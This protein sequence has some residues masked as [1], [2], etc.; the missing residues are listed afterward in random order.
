MIPEAELVKFIIQTVAD[1]EKNKP[2]PVSLE[3]IDWKKFKDFISYHELVS[4]AYIA[5]KDHIS[6]LPVDLAQTLKA[7]YYYT[8]TQTQKFWRRFLDIVAAAK[9]AG[10]VILPIKGTALLN[11]L[12]LDIPVR[13][14]VDVDLLVKEEDFKKA[15]DLLYKLGYQKE[16][17]GLTE[18]YWKLDQCHITYQGRGNGLPIAELHWG[19]DFKRNGR[20]I[21]PEIWQ[22]LREVDVDGQKIKLLS[23]E[24]TLFSLGLH[25]RRFGKTLCLKYACDV[26]L[27]LSK[28]KDSFDWRYILSKAKEYRL[29][30]VIYFILYN[31]KALSEINVPEYVWRDLGLPFWKRK[32]IHRFIEKNL[33]LSDADQKGKSLYLKSHFLLYD[34]L[35]EPAQYILNIP[36]EQFAKYYGLETY[37]KKTGFF[38]SWRLIY[39]PFMALRRKN[40]C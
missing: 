26:S 4:L 13:P 5:L 9:E 39:M 15:E 16:L 28:Y 7:S 34:S 1:K 38:Y 23:P 33:F 2:L 11:D 21:L 19:I 20:V 22:R 8:L 3:K 31:A 37:T 24:D 30:S 40:A 35:V 29:C 18:E 6:F 14:M 25:S 12:Y 36:K 32:L 17:G 27:L 10:V